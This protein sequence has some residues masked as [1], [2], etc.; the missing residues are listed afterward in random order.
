MCKGQIGSMNCQLEYLI[1]ELPSDFAGV[2]SVITS[3]YSVEECALKVLFDF[4]TPVDQS[5]SVQQYRIGLAQNYY[6]IFSGD[7]PTPTPS[8]KIYIVQPGDT[9]Y[10]IAQRFNT[11]GEILCKLNNITNPDLIQVGQVLILP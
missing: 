9:L 5:Y 3:S 10:S 8:D 2:Y 7:T 1:R 6:N 11:T 4:E